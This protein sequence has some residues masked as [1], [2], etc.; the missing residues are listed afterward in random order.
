MTY[1]IFAF[2]DAVTVLG[3]SVYVTHTYLWPALN[4]I[5]SLA[6]SLVAST[7]L[8]MLF[9]PRRRTIP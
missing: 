1:N 6:K 8:M 9:L 3:L 5:L 7:I 4:L 2:L